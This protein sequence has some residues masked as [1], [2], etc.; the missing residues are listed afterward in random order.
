MSQKIWLAL[1]LASPLSWAGGLP[2]VDCN[3][4][5]SADKF[6]EDF[7]SFAY[8]HRWGDRNAGQGSTG[9]KLFNIRNL[10]GD[11]MRVSTT[12]NFKPAP[13]WV[14]DFDLFPLPIHYSPQTSQP[15][16]TVNVT[17]LKLSGEVVKSFLID[18]EMPPKK[19]DEPT[20]DELIEIIRERLDESERRMIGTEYYGPPAT[21]VGGTIW[22]VPRG[23]PIV[24]IG[25]DYSSCGSQL[26]CTYGFGM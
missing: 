4:C 24:T 13:R 9:R 1:L 22:G 21:G 12:V 16:G 15:D 2:L 20:L 3:G 6:P 23:T 26:V 17:V 8:H 10:R 7:A 11:T 18:H 25:P 19:I 14:L 5:R